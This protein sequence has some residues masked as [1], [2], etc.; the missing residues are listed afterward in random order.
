M[1]DDAPCASQSNISEC[2]GSLSSWYC[3]NGATCFSVCIENSTLYNCRCPAGFHGARCD[4]KYTVSHHRQQTASKRDPLDSENQI[5][6]S[7]HQGNDYNYPTALNL[8]FVGA[9]HRSQAEESLIVSHHSKQQLL[10]KHD[11]ISHLIVTL[12]YVSFICS[13]LILIWLIHR[14]VVSHP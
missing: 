10:L 1:S 2:P 11:R 9:P 4:F 7:N 6:D 8:S 14:Y 12:Y 13:I 5:R 3:L